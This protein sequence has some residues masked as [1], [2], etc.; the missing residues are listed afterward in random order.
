MNQKNIVLY[1]ILW[2]H[3]LFQTGC[4]TYITY[5]WA[6]DKEPMK[7]KKLKTKN[8][9]YSKDNRL[10]INFEGKL[11]R[12]DGNNFHMI[13]DVDTALVV[14]NQSFNSYPKYQYDTLRSVIF[15]KVKDKN[16]NCVT[17]HYDRRL[18]ESGYLYLGEMKEI[19]Q[20]KISMP[21]WYNKYWSEED[22]FWVI[23]TDVPIKYK[24]EIANEMMIYISPESR[25]RYRRFLMLPIAVLGD[26]VTLP[27]QII[28]Y[29][30]FVKMIKGIKDR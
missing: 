8:A 10:V 3:L 26:V 14:M 9:Y 4:F 23:Q 16:E 17:L 7:D 29:K 22:L 6:S 11:K 20:E 27:F 18:I 30:L 2:V 15:G 13:A 28:F 1:F 25:I 5:D 24:E 21:R 19:N 12:K